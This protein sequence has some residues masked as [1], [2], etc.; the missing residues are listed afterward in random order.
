MKKLPVFL[1]ALYIAFHA[2]SL[3]LQA[4]NKQDNEVSVWLSNIDHL[5]LALIIVQVFK[6]IN[7][8]NIFYKIIFLLTVLS[9]IGFFIVNLL[10]EKRDPEFRVIAIILGLVWLVWLIS[11]FWTNFRL[12][13]IA[14]FAAMAIVMVLFVSRIASPDIKTFINTQTR[15]LIMDIPL[16]VLMYNFIRKPV[17]VDENADPSILHE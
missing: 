6:E 3:Y 13:A 2:L 8:K 15:D 10:Y 11:L 16:L 1:I 17:D 14:Y 5:V 4:G 9:H 7:K 12:Y